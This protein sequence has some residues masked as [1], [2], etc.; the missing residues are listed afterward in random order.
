MI[1]SIQELISK[2]QSILGLEVIGVD[3]CREPFA[4]VIKEL[5][6]YN[7]SILGE[8]IQV[9]VEWDYNPGHLEQYKPHQFSKWEGQRKMGVYYI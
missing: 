9:W 7:H 8:L 5:S 1:N 2:E 3:G 6:I 4:G